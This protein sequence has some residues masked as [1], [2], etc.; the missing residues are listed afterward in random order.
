[1][2]YALFVQPF[3]SEP[4]NIQVFEIAA[5]WIIYMVMLAGALGSVTS[6]MFR[7]QDF[8]KMTESDPLI[9]LLTGLFKPLIGVFFALF[10]FSVNQ[11]GIVTIP[12]GNGNYNAFLF[13]LAFV[14]G[15]SE[16]F[17]KDV[18][19]RFDTTPP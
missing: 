12:V 9:L 5:A 17:V 19:A 18:A 16:R 15:F 1:V 2:S 4:W 7:I 11:A 13:V 8:N 10:I 3:T 14:A 6:I